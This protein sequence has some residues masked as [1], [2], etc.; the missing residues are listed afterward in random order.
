[1]TGDSLTT[2][3]EH[4]MTGEEH[5]MT[6]EEHLMTGEEHLMTGEEHRLTVGPSR[7]I[8]QLVLRF[9]TRSTSQSNR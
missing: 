1:M 8:P 3:E 4:L 9:T 6:G 7:S 2:G 5:L